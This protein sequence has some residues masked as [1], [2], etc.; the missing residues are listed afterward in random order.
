M[1][2]AVVYGTLSVPVK[3]PIAS[4][5]SLQWTPDGQLLVLGET[6]QEIG[7]KPDG[8]GQLG[9]SDV[10]GVRWSTTAI[11]LQATSHFWPEICQG[12]LCESRM[13][14]QD[15]MILSC[16]IV[17]L[18][19][20]LEVHVWTPKEN[21]YRGEWIKLQDVTRDLCKVTLQGKTPDVA[22]VL[23]AQI[24]DLLQG[25]QEY[26]LACTRG[27]IHLI[28]IYYDPTSV[29]AQFQIQLS[30]EEPSRLDP[31]GITAL[32]WI[33]PQGQD[34]GLSNCGGVLTRPTGQ[35]VT[36]YN[37]SFKMYLQ[38]QPVLARQ[39]MAPIMPSSISQNGL[40]LVNQRDEHA[41]EEMTACIERPTNFLLESPFSVLQGPFVYLQQKG[42][43]LRN[44]H[45][46]NDLI[47]PNE[48]NV[49]RHLMRTNVSNN[50]APDEWREAA[51][52]YLTNALFANEA[53]NKDRLKLNIANNK[54]QIRIHM[55]TLLSSISPTG[56]TLV[57]MMLTQAR[58][59]TLQE[60]VQVQR[61]REE[62]SSNSGI[63]EQCAACGKRI[64]FTELDTGVC[65]SGHYW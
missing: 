19:S 32:E 52:N 24:Q 1:A 38:H 16:L 5:R 9:G 23:R 25:T 2:S 41:I 55:P 51:Q 22:S 37:L 35:D 49:P 3:P 57:R 31:R 21:P 28:D 53:L 8:D 42:F 27:G 65:E 46:I 54:L 61:I 56:S 6:T 62:T 4:S 48:D 30:L 10:N 50:E 64:E 7:L 18:S 29:E 58:L 15:L 45:H 60:E 47:E 39:L 43:L 33:Y 26:V 20:N 14:V 44:K 34:L 63:E 17:T 12:L 59:F 40:L 36:L 13:D 11:P